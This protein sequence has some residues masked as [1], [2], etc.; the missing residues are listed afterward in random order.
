MWEQ[1]QTSITDSRDGLKTRQKLPQTKI[2]LRFLGSCG[3]VLDGRISSVVSGKLALVVIGRE[4]L[5]GGHY[6]G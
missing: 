2:C 3:P 6:G 5:P 1:P 4:N